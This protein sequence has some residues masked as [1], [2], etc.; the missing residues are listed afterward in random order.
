MKINWL[1]EK[2]VVSFKR[3]SSRQIIS[4]SSNCEFIFKGGG[5]RGG[6]Q[7][8]PKLALRIRQQS[9]ASFETQQSEDSGCSGSA[10]SGE[11]NQ[12]ALM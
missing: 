12:A 8:D 7:G 3:A 1:L 2:Y 4:E 10:K 5:G 9:T 6:D 11:A